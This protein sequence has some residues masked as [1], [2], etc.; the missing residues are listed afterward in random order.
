MRGITPILSTVLIIAVACGLAVAIYYWLTPYSSR[1]LVPPEVSQ[2][3]I[4]VEECTGST[5]IIKNNFGQ[6]VENGTRFVIHNLTTGDPSG[7]NVT[8]TPRLVQG[9][10]TAYPVDCA[11]LATGSYFLR[12]TKYLDAYFTC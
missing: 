5:L 2:K 4:Y 3:K 9:N 12:A 1:A 11:G 8:I 6:E 7:C 10:R